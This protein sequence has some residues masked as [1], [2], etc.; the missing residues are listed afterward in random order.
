VVPHWIGLARAIRE[1]E[2]MTERDRVNSGGL[3][4][5]EVVADTV[6]DLALDQSSARI[7]VIRAHRDPYDVDPASPDPQEGSVDKLSR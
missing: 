3:V 5:P 6:V 7:V 4:D 1:F 2:Q